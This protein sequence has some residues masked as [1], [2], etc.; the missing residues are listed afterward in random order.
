MPVAVD[1]ATRFYFNK[2]DCI[3]S[4]MNQFRKKT[5]GDLFSI[6]V[7]K[8]PENIFIHNGK[9]KSKIVFKGLR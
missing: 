4:G 1:A 7:G 9:V 6:N 8:L 2:I 5:R 3:V